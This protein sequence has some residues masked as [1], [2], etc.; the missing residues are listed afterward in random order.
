[1]KQTGK[2][3]AGNR[4][5]GFDA[6]GA[7]NQLTVRL[8]RHSQRKR[9]AT[10]RLNLRSAAPVLDPTRSNHPEVGKRGTKGESRGLSG[11]CPQRGNRSS[12]LVEDEDSS[13]HNNQ[14]QKANSQG[15][16]AASCVTKC[17]IVITAHKSHP[18]SQPIVTA[19]GYLCNGD[20]TPVVARHYCFSF[21][22]KQLWAASR[23]SLSVI[24]PYSTHGFLPGAMK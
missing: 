2:P 19:E 16:I 13:P 1:M 17:E 8:M 12:S 10:A 3:I 21:I 4:H 7:G 9:G 20:V 15:Y 14:L 24:T 6:A 11:L 18:I 22:P 5:D 23:R